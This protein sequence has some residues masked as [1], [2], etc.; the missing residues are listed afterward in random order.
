MTIRIL[1]VQTTLSAYNIP[2]F[3]K[4][5]RMKGVE[6]TLCSFDDEIDR[7]MYSPTEESLGFTYIKLQQGVLTGWFYSR[8]GFYLSS[9][10][11]FKIINQVSPN[12]IAIDGLTSVGNAFSIFLSKVHKKIPVIWWSLG[13]IP[14]RKINVR[15]TIGD[16]LQK[17]FAGRAASVFSYGTYSKNYFES[18]GISEDKIVVGYNTIDEQQVVN[19]VDSVSQDDILLLREDLGIPKENTV[20]AYCGRLTEGKRVDILIRSIHQ[21][22]Q[23]GKGS[24]SL[25]IIGNGPERQR[26]EELASLLGLCSEIVF[27]GQQYTNLSKYFL[28][29]DFCVLPGLGGLAINH[30]FAHGLPVVCGPAD[31]TERDLVKTGETGVLL[32]DVDT[33]SLGKA[34][35]YMT[36]N[37]DNRTEMGRN[38]RKLILGNYSLSNYA[39]RFVKLALSIRN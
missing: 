13:S 3:E 12:V 21:L 4:I 26:L 5:G 8:F 17:F 37:A 35:E 32:S 23:I 16:R 28:L 15:S 14:D 36:D 9:F 25:V 24:L 6:L 7:T 38:A 10:D 33:E 1:I 11:L 27:V 19:D 29:G 34:I 2:L 30:A 20:I 39:K 22:K 18:I 31:G